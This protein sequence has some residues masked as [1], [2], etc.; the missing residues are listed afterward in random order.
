[1][2]LLLL[3]ADSAYYVSA[4]I[5][6]AIRA[7][8]MVSITAKLNSLVKAAISTIPET[9]WTPIKY[10]NAIFDDT[11]GRWISDAEVAEVPFTAFG[12][13]KKSEQVSGRLVVRRIP[14]LNKTVT[15]GQG[16]L[17]DLFRFHAFFTTSTLNTVEADKTHR[18][19][20]C[21]SWTPVRRLKITSGVFAANAAWLVLA[22]IAF[23]RASA[24]AATAG[25]GLARATTPTIRRKLI[26]IPARIASSARRITLH[27][28]ENW[29]WEMS[30]THLFDHVFAPPSPT[31]T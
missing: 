10:T 1:M 21:T 7:G 8:A 27:L 20:S 26:N 9:A 11:T 18:Q 22:V 31:P 4:V 6:A 17:F 24:A 29:P 28:P 16:T 19:S 23:N 13:K 5:K 25:T 14:E 15:A 30:W 12:S 2:G 3:R